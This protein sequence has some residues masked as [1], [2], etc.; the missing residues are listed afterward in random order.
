MKKIL[1]LFIAVIF[2]YTSFAQDKNP[3]S[4]PKIISKQDKLLLN[5]NWDNWLNTTTGVDVKAFRSRGFSFLIMNEKPFGEGNF[6]IAW[7]LGFSSQNV[8]S[9]TTPTYNDDG[10]KTYLTPIPSTTDYDLNKLSCNFIDA[11]F[12]LR[13]RS[14]ENEH[15]KRFKITAGIKAGYL[16]QSHTKFET[17]DMKIKTYNIKNLN[18]FQY[19]LTGRIGYARWGFSGYYSLINLFKDGKGPDVVPVSIGLS[20]AL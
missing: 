9:N 17:D 12:E 5:L 18:K 10:S 16:V 11:A 7:G 20:Y 8:H 1:P 6:A 3:M 13:L 2:S 15:S 14:N 19:G 4:I